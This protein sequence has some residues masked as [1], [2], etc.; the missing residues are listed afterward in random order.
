MTGLNSPVWSRLGL[1]P[2][3]PADKG[4]SL[5]ICPPLQFRQLVIVNDELLAGIGTDNAVDAITPRLAPLDD[6]SIRSALDRPRAQVQQDRLHPR[7]ELLNSNRGVGLPNVDHVA[8]SARH[9]RNHQEGL[10][11]K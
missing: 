9:L 3:D 2:A 4:T 11:R 7:A 10:Y 1:F 6:Q 8:T 5:L